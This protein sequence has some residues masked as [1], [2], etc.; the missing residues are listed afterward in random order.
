M[1]PCTH[2]RRWGVLL[3]LILL[4]LP[5]GAHEDHDHGPPPA[6]LTPGERLSALFRGQLPEVLPPVDPL[7]VTASTQDLTVTLTYTPARLIAGVVEPVTFRLREPDTGDPLIPRIANV[8]ITFPSGEMQ[9][10]PLQPVPRDPGNYL[11]EEPW[12]EAGAVSLVVEAVRSGQPLQAPAMAVHVKPPPVP[13]VP[14]IAL[15]GLLALLTGSALSALARKRSLGA[16]QQWG[17]A[18]VAG[19]LLAAGVFGAITQPGRA[20][21]A[22]EAL[23]LA[24]AVPGE[25][26][27]MPVSAPDGHEG[28][29]HAHD[30]GHDHAHDDHSHD[31]P[32]ATP[33][34]I[35]V[36]DSSRAVLGRLVIPDDARAVISA[37]QGG[38]LTSKTVLPRGTTVAAGQTLAT[39]RVLNTEVAPDAALTAGEEAAASAR[40][41]SAQSALDQAQRELA[42]SERLY[43]AGIIALRELEERQT[44][45]AT[46]QADLAAAQGLQQAAAKRHATLTAAG[47][48]G[49]YRTVTLTSPIAGVITDVGISAGAYVPEGVALYTIV[50]PGRLWI[51]AQ[52]YEDQVA[53]LDP[54]AVWSFQLAVNPAARFEARV[55]SRGL[56]F[57]PHTR[58]L[59]VLFDV[60]SSDPAL[61]AGQQVLLQP[62]AAGEE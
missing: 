23:V 58:T 5:A 4:A 57:D 28:H 53:A 50:T 27:Q 55:R 36:P 37:P 29:D 1:V 33:A 15:G 39:L 13:V 60:N 54:G 14:Y 42:R 34:A 7:A 56:E 31:A 26:V 52:L 61:I 49:A 6:P 17:S 46:A 20:I 16:L 51:E 11:I 62:S 25:A 12:P 41:A 59:P 40:V 9:T 48:S 10:V 32:A 3:L 30:D 18:V 22:A 2:R 8:R 21:R 45:V 19:G 38:T 35:P 47:G 24:A 43:D 44:A